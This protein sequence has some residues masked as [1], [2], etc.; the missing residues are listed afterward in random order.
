MKHLA[1]GVPVIEMMVS[2]FVEMT[3]ETPALPSRTMPA[4]V[5]PELSTVSLMTPFPLLY[6]PNVDCP[7]IVRVAPMTVR[8]PLVTLRTV[9]FDP[10]P[11]VVLVVTVTLLLMRTM[12]P[13]PGGVKPPQV[14][15][16]D[17]LPDWVEVT[18]RA[19]EELVA[20]EAAARLAER[21]PGAS[22]ALTRAE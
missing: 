19:T 10:S 8:V 21:L 5:V 16:L 17:Q 14:A 20:A 18:V 15:G 2:L 4:G 13:A 7:R 3:G 22:A 12:S 1:D 11:I 6:L 9:E